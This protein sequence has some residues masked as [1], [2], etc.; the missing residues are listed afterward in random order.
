MEILRT[1]HLPENLAV[2][3]LVKIFLAFHKS[4]LAHYYTKICF[5][6]TIHHLRS[7]SRP[8]SFLQV[9]SQTFSTH[10]SHP[11]YKVGGRR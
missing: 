7:N 2:A 11:L 3:Q 8:V 4:R 1:K 6:I 9:F 5:N 10:F